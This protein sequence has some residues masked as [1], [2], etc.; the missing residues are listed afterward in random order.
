MENKINGYYLKF[1]IIINVD[2]Q[3]HIINDTRKELRY[4]G[5]IY[6]VKRYLYTILCSVIKNM[7]KRNKLKF[8]KF[9]ELNIDK[10]DFGQRVVFEYNRNNNP[11]INWENIDKNINKR[12]Y[13][14]DIFRPTMM[15]NISLKKDIS[16]YGVV[17]HI[18]ID[19]PVYYSLS[20]SGYEKLASRHLYIVNDV[21]NKCFKITGSTKIR[22]KKETEEH[23]KEYEDANINQIKYHDT[24]YYDSTI[25]QSVTYLREIYNLCI[26]LYEYSSNKKDDR[27]YSS[28]NR[29]IEQ[30][31]KL[32]KLNHMELE[33]R[34]TSDDEIEQKIDKLREEAEVLRDLINFRNRIK[35][36]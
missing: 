1:G 7:C 3:T 16:D 26:K 11:I 6:I 22:E 31:K 25:L 36:K 34:G 35:N 23:F 5:D 32:D 8:D 4:V 18:D 30:M 17:N 19:I 24:I 9:T 27:L 28:I 12:E 13:L 10:D 2:G 21:E 29:V 15:V 33:Y 14:E 20:F